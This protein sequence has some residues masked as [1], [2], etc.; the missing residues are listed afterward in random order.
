MRIWL[1]QTNEEEFS[2]LMGGLGWDATLRE[3]SRPDKSS[4]HVTAW[5]P[6][7]SFPDHVSPRKFHHSFQTSITI[8]TS[9][10]L[11]NFD[12]SF[13][14]QWLQRAAFS[15][16]PHNVLSCSSTYCSILLLLNYCP[17]TV[18]TGEFGQQEA[19]ICMWSAVMRQPPFV[20]LP[21]V[22]VTRWYNYLTNV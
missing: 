1:H 18:S 19:T 12:T 9:W 14:S 3:Q 13:S 7:V 21:G 17:A 10:T 4:S 15:R 2:A 16:S 11:T 6:V 5:Q 22:L 20:S 8:V